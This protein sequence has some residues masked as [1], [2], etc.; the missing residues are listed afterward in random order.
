[1]KNYRFKVKRNASK[2]I[3]GM[4]VMFKKCT[5]CGEV[6]FRNEFQKQ[7]RQPTGL[8]SHCK[9]C[10]RSQY[11]HTC[12]QCGK[13]FKGGKKEQR[14][15][16]HK[17]Q[18]QWYS[19]NL[20]GENHPNYNRIK[21]NCDYCGKEIT[22][23]KSRY[24]K[25][26]NH[27]CNME[28]R[29]KWNSE[30]LI[31]E[32]HQNYN[33]NITQEER[34]QGRSYTEYR[35]FIKDVYKRD[36]YTCQCCGDNKGHNLNAHHIYGYTEYKNFRTDIDNGITL[37]EECHKKYHKQYGYKNN[38]YKDFRTFLYNE[39]IKQNTLEAR[40]FYANVLEDITLRFEIKY[41][42]IWE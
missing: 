18:G 15:C 30:N 8:N 13:E 22:V 28:C 41:I 2:N 6:L 5:K 27:F 31:G 25:Y 1:M 26:D 36:N 38:N 40:L 24:D 11:S 42:N 14:F 39:M 35:D 17:C 3:L 10:R 9:E 37:C 12:E 21:I 7:K 16:S 23:K 29:G 20:K 4:R 32:N 34:E 19:E 33:P